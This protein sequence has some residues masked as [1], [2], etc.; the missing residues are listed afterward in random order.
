MEEINNTTMNVSSTNG[1]LSDLEM[2]EYNLFA[3]ESNLNFLETDVVEFLSHDIG[4]VFLEQNKQQCFTSGSTPTSLCNSS[5]YETNLDSFD[6]DFDKPNMELKTIDHIHSNK[7]NETFSPKLSPSNSSIQFQ[8]PSFDNTPNSPTTNSSQLCGLDPTFNSKQNSEIKTSKS[9]RS[10]TLHGQDHIM[11]ERKR[12]EKLTQNFIALAALVPNLKKVDK[13][14]VLVDTI[15]YLKELKK[16]LK[17][18]E[19]QNEKT[20]IES[21]VVV[22]TKQAFAT[23]TTPPHVMRVLIVLLIY[24]FKWK[25]ES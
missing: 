11:A 22:L 8:I 10:R 24:H 21:L 14:S 7:I 6:F 2:D 25:Q 5:S 4:N 15:K 20:K 1:W 18:L 13:Y 3:E 16:R 23:M 12:R 9:K 19:E 17:V